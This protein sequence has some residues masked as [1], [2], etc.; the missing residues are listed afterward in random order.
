MQVH[1]ESKIY[2]YKKKIKTPSVLFCFSF[3][4]AKRT[5]LILW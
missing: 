2:L 3:Y 4:L 5:R 1:K